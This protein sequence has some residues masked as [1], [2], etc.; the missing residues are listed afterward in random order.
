MVFRHFPCLENRERKF[1]RCGNRDRHSSWGTLL[2][3]YG[4]PPKQG[5]GQKSNF[6]AIF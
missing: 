2:N 1:S 4:K 5:T 3:G 6:G